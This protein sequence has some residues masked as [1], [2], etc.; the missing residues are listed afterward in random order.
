MRPI[1]IFLL[2]FVLLAFARV[3]HKHRQRE[4]WGMDLFFWLA[5]WAGAMLL[6]LFPE[7][8]TALANLL[9]IWRGADLLLYVALIVLFYLVFR[10]HLVLERLEQSLTEVVRTLAL[11]Q[12][13]P[14]GDPGEAR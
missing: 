1:Q 7:S 12:L 2:G 3:L 10:I 6:L 9:G 4:I 8:T 11:Q 13:P 14:A 5:L